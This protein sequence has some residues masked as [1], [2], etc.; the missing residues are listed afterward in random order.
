MKYQ[1]HAL[2]RLGE[3]IF[4]KTKERAKKEYAVSSF[5]FIKNIRSCI[6]K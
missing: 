6:N 1:R 5:Y 2:L 4:T 3:L